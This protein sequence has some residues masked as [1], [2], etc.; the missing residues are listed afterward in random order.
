MFSEE[1]LLSEE[2]TAVRIPFRLGTNALPGY[3]FL[4]LCPSVTEIRFTKLSQHDTKRTHLGDVYIF[5]VRFHGI[6]NAP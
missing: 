4:S 5:T 1:F 2:E 6:Y 3:F